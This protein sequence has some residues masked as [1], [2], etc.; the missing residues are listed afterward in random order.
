M[1]GGERKAGHHAEEGALGSGPG[2]APTSCW[3]W[4]SFLIDSKIPSAL[5]VLG[6][7]SVG[8]WAPLG[9]SLGEMGRV[10]RQ[11]HRLR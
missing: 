3:P 11:R 5:Q 1:A 6:E 4:V 7:G 10:W 8:A 9:G 2:S